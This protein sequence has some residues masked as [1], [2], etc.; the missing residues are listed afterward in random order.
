M[1]AAG[2][3]GVAKVFE[4][5]IGGDD[6]TTLDFGDGNQ[7]LRFLLGRE[8]KRLVVIARKNGDDS[9]LVKGCAFNDDPSINHFSSRNSHDRNSTPKMLSHRW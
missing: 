4:K 3:S 7:Q 5:L 8:I 6:F 9:T 2:S 1:R